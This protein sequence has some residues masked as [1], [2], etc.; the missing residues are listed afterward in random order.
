MQFFKILNEIKNGNSLT[1]SL[2]HFEV[3]NCYIGGRVLDVGGGG[4]RP[5][6]LDFFKIN[7]EYKWENIDQKANKEFNLEV[8]RFPYAEESIDQILI[9]NLL[10]HIYNH[11][12]VIGESFR[13]L[14][15]EGQMIGFVPFMINYHPDPH[16]YFRYTKEALFRIF[17]EAGFDDIVI[18]EVGGGPFLVN[19][20][21][22][23]LSIPIILR[24]LLF[25]FYYY[26]DCLFVKLRPKSRSR[27]PLGYYFVL[28]K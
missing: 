16:D 20:N 22:I 14:K 17:S 28:K 27:Y 2:I 21:N 12:F 11:K 24:L 19:Y 5:R 7:R 4:G 26:L 15:K 23:V 9:F 3:E 25:P 8:D 13:V 18:K 1:R 6:Y 10:E